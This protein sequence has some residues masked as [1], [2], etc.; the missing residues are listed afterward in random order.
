MSG[1]QLQHRV[2][3]FSET[4]EPGEEPTQKA[5]GNE[6]YQYA[7]E[8]EEDEEDEGERQPGGQDKQDSGGMLEEFKGQ[9]VG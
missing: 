8:D 6:E 3:P 1:R 2:P 9:Y 4:E 7:Y 5:E